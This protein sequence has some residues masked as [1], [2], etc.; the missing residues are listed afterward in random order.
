MKQKIATTLAKMNEGKDISPRTA[1]DALEITAVSIRIGD[2]ASGLS[3]RDL[4]I[5]SRNRKSLGQ[6]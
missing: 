2:D 1:K 3:T 5:A 4:N 6:R